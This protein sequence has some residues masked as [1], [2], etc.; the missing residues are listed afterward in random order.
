MLAILPGDRRQGPRVAAHDGFEGELNR[1]IEVGGDE[2]AAAFDDV[3][4]VGL[5]GVGGVVEAVAEEDADEEIGEAV[6]EEFDAWVVEDFTAADEAAAEGAFVALVEQMPVAHGVSGGVR[7]VGH[8]DDNGVTA[9]VIQTVNNGAAEAVRA[10][11]L[12]GGERGDFGTEGL[13]DGPRGVFGGI[14]DDNEFVREA[15]ARECG[16]DGAERGRQGGFFVTGGDD[17]GEEGEGGRRGRRGRHV[18]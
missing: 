5:E 17:D 18:R 12:D 13:E 6:D 4:A 2:R 9:H 15:G 11:I 16:V 8:H 14:I 3:A 10:G 1:E 7:G